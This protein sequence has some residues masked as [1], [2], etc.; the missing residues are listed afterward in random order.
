MDIGHDVELQKTRSE[1][2][3]DTRLERPTS[4]DAQTQADEPRDSKTDN[5]NRPGH[6]AWAPD[7]YRGQSLRIPS[8][9]AQEKGMTATAQ[10]EGRKLMILA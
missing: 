6:I 7:A 4:L 8:P 3:V 5:Q 9:L 10:C 2:L 1:G